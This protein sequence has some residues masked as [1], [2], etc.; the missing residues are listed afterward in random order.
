MEGVICV[1]MMVTA[2]V[3]GCVDFEKADEIYFRLGIIYKQLQRYNESLR[4]FDQ[5][6]Q[7][8]PHPLSQMD[9]WF[10]IGHV[11][12]QQKDYDSAKDAWDRVLSEAP[13]HAKVLQ[14]LGWL[15]HQQAAP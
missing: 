6:L 13:K 7:N 5:I 9:I 2:L 1:L 12:E 10:Q 3:V 14:Q 11:Y 8:P 4:C 15:Y